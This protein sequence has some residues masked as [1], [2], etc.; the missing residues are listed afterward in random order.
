M[1]TERFSRAL[2]VSLGTIKQ[3]CHPG[4]VWLGAFL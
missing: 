2:Y 1:I 3:G 4:G